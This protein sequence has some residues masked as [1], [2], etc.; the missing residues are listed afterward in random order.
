MPVTDKY[1]HSAGLRTAFR[2]WL[3]SAQDASLLAGLTFVVILGI[4][5]LLELAAVALGLDPNFRSSNSTLA[6]SISTALDGNNLR[7]ILRSAGFAT[8]AAILQFAVALLAARR[9][10]ISGPKM[11]WLI[12]LLL[13]PLSITPIAA[14]LMWKSL[15]DLQ[16]GLLNQLI[17]SAGLRRIPWLSTLPVS[18]PPVF[19]GFSEINWGQV[20]IL[21]ADSWLWTPFLIGGQLLA[22]SRVPHRLLDAARL[23]GA[24]SEQIFWRLVCPLSMPYLSLLFFLRF[25]D[26]YR[27]FDNA[28]AFF[29]EQAPI[30]QFTSRVYA[31]GYLG[32]DYAAAAILAIAGTLLVTPVT[33]YL[34][35]RIRQILGRVSREENG[36]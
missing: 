28:W 32:R 30:A 13:V 21:L 22:F 17:A 10:F 16:F 8:I 24:N 7:S 23:E 34:L 19:T 14:S 12:L 2:L 5:P 26:G 4:L 29:G 3:P 20:S 25:V 18:Y 11:R 27:A 1:R 9:L 31:V 6:G 15:M 35:W 36:N 33:T